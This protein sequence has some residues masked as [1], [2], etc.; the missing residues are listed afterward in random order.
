MKTET[1]AE[2][3]LK[4]LSDVLDLSLVAIGDELQISKAYAHQLRSGERELPQKLIWRL[5]TR[6]GIH[7]DSLINEGAPLLDCSGSEYTRESYRRH[8]S[9]QPTPWEDHDSDLAMLTQLFNAAADAGRLNLLRA[10]LRDHVLQLFDHMPDLDR[11]FRKQFLRPSST[12]KTDERVL[13]HDQSNSPEKDLSEIFTKDLDCRSLFAR[14]WK[15]PDI[16]VVERSYA[17]AVEFKAPSCQ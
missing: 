12:I 5:V 4:R 17:V 16:V 13:S 2:T 15:K 14:D 3:P 7:P 9:P 1:P 11:S 10:V 8:L 6:F